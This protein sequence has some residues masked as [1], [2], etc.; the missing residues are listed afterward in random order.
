MRDMPNCSIILYFSPGDPSLA[1]SP[2]FSY[3]CTNSSPGW[4]VGANG[5]IHP[6]SKQRIVQIR[7]DLYAFELVNPAAQFAGF[8]MGLVNASRKVDSDSN[9]TPKAELRKLGVRILTPRYPTKKSKTWRTSAPLVFDMTEAKD[10]LVYS[11][12][13]SAGSSDP[14]WDDPKIYDDGSQ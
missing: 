5:S 8:R 4:S 9:W 12:A 6:P 14:V 11:L 13:V 10:R 3:Y 2:S 1:T 7:L